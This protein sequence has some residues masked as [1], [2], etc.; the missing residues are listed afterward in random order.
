MNS[1]NSLSLSD[2]AVKYG[3]DKYGSHFYTPRYE[4]HLSRYKNKPVTLIEIGVGGY[5]DKSRGGQSLRMWSEWFTHPGC[6]IIGVDIEDK[7][8]NIDD[9]RVFFRR[10]SQVSCEF[11][12]SIVD[13]FGLPDVVIDDGS[14]RPSDVIE[15]FSFL[16]PL[17]SDDAIYIVEDTQT[18]YWNS[19]G[20]LNLHDP[21]H[22]YFKRLVESIN[23]AELPGQPRPSFFDMNVS[24]LHFYHNLIIIDKSPNLEE[25][26]V[27]PSRTASSV[28]TDGILISA[29]DSHPPQAGISLVVHIGGIGDV[30]A[31]ESLSAIGCARDNQ[32][33]QGFMLMVDRCNTSEWSDLRYRVIDVDGCWSG[34]YSVNQFA[35][36]RG[37]SRNISGFQVL[38]ENGR[39]ID[40]VALF[41]DCP[42]RPLLASRGAACVSS[43]PSI[44]L[45]GMQLILAQV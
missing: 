21:T 12:T 27:V 10:G 33:I 13:E 15:T 14:H 40:S 28:R 42:N 7:D 23:Y 17:M 43:N 19:V 25:S 32:C 3:S 30:V 2:L 31:G 11:L 18:S 45:V 37:I 5:T 41:A 29:L 20:G 6:V 9:K 44:P 38:S 4:T 26:N 1:V 22:S 24:G 16:F 34:F 8:L 36:S 39:A 35:G